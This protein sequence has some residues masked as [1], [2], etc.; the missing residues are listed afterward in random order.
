LTGQT[1]IMLVCPVFIFAKTHVHT[2]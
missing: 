1:G 2:V